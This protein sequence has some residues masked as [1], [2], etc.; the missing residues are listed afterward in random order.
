MTILIILT[1]C[2]S[3]FDAEEYWEG[4]D[5]NSFEAKID[6]ATGSRPGSVSIRDFNNDGK[7]DLVVANEWSNSISI[8]LNTSV[9]SGQISFTPKIDHKTGESPSSMATGDFDNDGMI[10]LAI[11]DWN[12][13]AISVFRNTSSGE[14]ISFDD[15]IDIESP[16]TT[17]VTTGDLDGDGMMDLV[18]LSWYENTV[19]MLRNI[20]SGPGNIS[21][22]NMIAYATAQ[23]PTSASTGDL[24]SDNKV[25][26]VVTNQ[27]G[28]I[29][30]VYRNSSSNPGNIHFEREL[31]IIAGKTPVSTAIAD[32]D[33]DGKPDLAIS[34]W[35][36]HTVSVFKNISED[37]GILE[38]EGT[39]DNQTGSNPSFVI[40]GDL[41]Q[42]DKPDLIVTNSSRGTVSV[43]RNHST[44]GTILFARKG[45][46]GIF[47]QPNSVAIGDFDGD[48]KPDLAITNSFSHT[49]SILRRK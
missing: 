24:N 40:I 42:D 2:N 46:Y 37:H 26:L 30:S 9:E 4:V 41:N 34:N 43:F 35:D 29:V 11:A 44:V 38:F 22:D 45:D 5:V 12:G 16:K 19:N 48:G 47:S 21:F 20:S 36:S 10:D 3:D 17:Y 1:S 33:N 6:I 23:L 28:Q 31:N 13:P 49:V 18:V 32:L 25:D 8:F 14:I 39:E 15:R 27:I 7:V